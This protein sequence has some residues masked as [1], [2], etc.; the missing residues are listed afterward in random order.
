[1]N[2]TTAAHAVILD[3][4]V[5]NDGHAAYRPYC[6]TCAWQGDSWHHEDTEPDAFELALAEANEHGLSF[7]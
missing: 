1:M 5:S 2:N 4:F 7:A 6:N 3:S